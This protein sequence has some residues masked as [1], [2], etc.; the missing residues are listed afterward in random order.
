[1][2]AISDRICTRSLASRF[3]SGSSIRNACGWRT[4][5]RPIA[6]RWRWPPESAVGLRLEQL[7]EAEDA[8]RVAHPLVDLGL[9]QLLQLSPNAM[10]SNTL[11][12]G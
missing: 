11:M 6:T 5:A 10:L 3:D 7:V 2:R 1:M 12:C 4:M 8:R 9:R